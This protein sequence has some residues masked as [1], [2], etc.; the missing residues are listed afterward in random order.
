MELVTLTPAQTGLVRRVVGHYTGSDRLSVSVEQ[1]ADTA[2]IDSGRLRAI[3]D[4]HGNRL[5]Q[6]EIT[7]FVN[8][9]EEFKDAE[10]QE[11]FELQRHGL[12][13]PRTIKDVAE[14][15][16]QGNY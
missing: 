13:L 5:S 3:V 8:L 2:N 15:I 16:N 11:V 12:P 9:C 14:E 7:N 4:G 10:A 6:D 1:F